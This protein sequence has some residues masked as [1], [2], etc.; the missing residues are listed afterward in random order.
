MA[1]LGTDSPAKAK[2]GVQGA[3]DSVEGS[4]SEE[5]HRTHSCYVARALEVEERGLG[6]RDV[7]AH[8]THSVVD[9][10]K[11]RRFEEAV[12]DVAHNSLTS[13]GRGLVEVAGS[14]LTGPPMASSKAVDA[15]MLAGL[16]AG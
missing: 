16:V 10:R 11:G 7:V 4:T 12:V 1:D 14:V 13:Q 3:V 6:E 9:V 15:R 2:V 5:A 8:S